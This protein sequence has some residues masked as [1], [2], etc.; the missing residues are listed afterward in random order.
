MYSSKTLRDCGVKSVGNKMFFII[1]ILCKA[2]NCL[3]EMGK[4]HIKL[5][6]DDH[7]KIIRK[8]AGA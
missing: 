7:K 8:L 3:L 6:L 2:L 4:L 5:S 1:I